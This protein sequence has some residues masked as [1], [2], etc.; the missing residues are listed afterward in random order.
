MKTGLKL[1][2]IMPFTL[3][4]TVLHGET[5]DEILAMNESPVGVVVEVIE[6]GAIALEQTITAIGQAAVKIRQ[7]FPDLPVAVV[8]HGVEQFFLTSTSIEQ[9]QSLK[10]NV[11]KLVGDDVDLHVCGTHASWRGVTP[12]EY[13]EYIDVSPAGPAQINDYLNLGYVMLD[14]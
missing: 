7:K 3:I 11:Q 6:P 14:L 4:S 9:H 8:S 1:L 12:E 5:L 10:S 13:P 2:F